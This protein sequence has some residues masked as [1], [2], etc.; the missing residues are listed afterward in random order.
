MVLVIGAF[1]IKQ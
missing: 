1:Q